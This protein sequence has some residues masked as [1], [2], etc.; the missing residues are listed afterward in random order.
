MHY[1]V[2]AILMRLAQWLYSSAGS[3]NANGVRRYRKSF[4]KKFMKLKIRLA[5]WLYYS[6]GSSNA[7]GVRCYR[8]SCEN[9]FMN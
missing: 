1:I 7:N 6:A 5:Q 9:K 8:M 3:S 2:V 4:E